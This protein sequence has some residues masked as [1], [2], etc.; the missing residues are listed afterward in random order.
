M[1]KSLQII[2]LVLCSILI[3]FNAYQLIRTL[4]PERPI[5]FSGL[6]FAGLNEVLHNETRLGYITDMNMD[7][8]GHLAEYEQAQ[9]MLAPAILELNKTNTRFLIVN[10]SS[11][12][13]AYQ[14]LKALG[15]QPLKRNQFGVIL[16]QNSGYYP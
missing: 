3:A 15:A 8:T 4:A 9:Y 11:D 16:A 5:T 13:A 14:K 7:D 6:K 12:A 1:K 10:C 2:F